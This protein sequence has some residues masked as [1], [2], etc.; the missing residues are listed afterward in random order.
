[1]NLRHWWRGA[2]ERIL[3]WRRLRIAPGDALP[4][5]MPRRDL[6]LVRD[7]GEDWS[8]GMRC[9]CGCSEVIELALMSDVRPHWRLEVDRSGRPSLSPSVWRRTGCRS[10]FW[11]R[12]GRVAW[13]D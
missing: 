10:H 6:V 1:M 9:P 13:C 4:A 12:Y 7:D 5:E 8:V 3:P 2:R 11:V